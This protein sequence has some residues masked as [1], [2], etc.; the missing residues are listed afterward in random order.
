MAKKAKKRPG[1]WSQFVKSVNKKI[2][3]QN[4]KTSKNTR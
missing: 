1:Y 3:E 4:G 2:A